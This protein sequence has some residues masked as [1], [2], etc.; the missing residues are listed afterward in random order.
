MKPTPA[1]KAAYDCRRCGN[2]GRIHRK[3]HVAGPVDAKGEIAFWRESPCPNCNE[4][5]PDKQQEDR[6]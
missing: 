4:Y 5:A 6:R 2:T 1:E 3:I